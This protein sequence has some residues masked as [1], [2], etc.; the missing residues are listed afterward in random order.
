MRSGTNGSAVYFSCLAQLTHVIHQLV[1]V[2]L[3]RIQNTEGVHK[4][5]TI[6]ILH[7]VTSRLASLKLI[8]ASI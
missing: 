1:K 8:Y 2:V 6:L 5:I 7:I 4:Q 3:V